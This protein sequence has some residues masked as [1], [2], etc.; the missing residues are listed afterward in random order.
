MFE[1]ANPTPVTT[2]RSQAAV[3]LDNLIRRHLRVSDPG[4]PEAISKALRERYAEESQALD[5]EAA[6]LP[7]FKVTRIEPRTPA[8][9]SSSAELRQARADVGQDLAALTT[10]VLLKDIHPELRGWSHALSGA[11][12]EGT[13][14]ARFALDPW[15][16]DRAM[17]AR[18]LLGDYARVAR[19]V[20]ALSPN[21]SI[22]Y[23]QLAKS[24]DEVA[25]VILV[26]MGEA[27]AQ[28]GHGGGR[29]LL[30]APASELQARRDAVINALRNLVGTTQDG[31]GPNEWPRGLSAYR[32]VLNHLEDNGLTDLR[33]LFQENHVAR[34]LDEVVFWATRGSSEDLRALGAT[35]LL[36]LE[37]FRRLDLTVRRRVDPESPAL[38]T[39]LSAIR[40]FLDTFENAGSGYRLLY[41]ARPPI[42]FYGLYG[43]GG[44]DAPTQ[45]L[46]EVIQLRGRLAQML[47]CYLGCDCS[48]GLVRCQIML[49]KL[50]Y[51]TDR[52][53][54]LYALSQATRGNGP[55]EQRAVAYGLIA[56]RLLRCAPGTQ[57]SVSC[58]PAQIEDVVESPTS[59]ADAVLCEDPRC[60]P[61]TCVDRYPGLVD[62]VKGIRDQL[63]YNP[64]SLIPVDDTCDIDITADAEFDEDAFSRVM[65]EL[66][67]QR[68]AEEQW[69]HLLQTMAPGCRFDGDTLGPTR[70]LVQ[71]AIDALTVLSPAASCPEDFDIP[72]HFE[73]SLAARPYRRGSA[74]E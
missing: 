70:D 30:Q 57:C 73:T 49:D 32:Q 3:A 2:E 24:L 46:L 10:N 74:G 62:V 1:Q 56:D 69:E 18:R 33:A 72:P 37:R 61:V 29:F 6:G 23:R 63:W 4:D 51:D 71:A 35:A 68:D 15:Q 17:A 16:R 50:L 47:D 40:L 36:A 44:P 26:T 42:A 52:A 58:E 14:A 66:C 22:H 39:Y 7:F 20:G 59:P 64:G 28:A 48:E 43:V 53:I 21:L 11:V 5:Q 27:V 38:A 45:R 8:N 67:S 9:G 13:N 31:Y 12:S 19:Y 41:I 55:A 65:E 34:S 25:N 54:D 60:Q